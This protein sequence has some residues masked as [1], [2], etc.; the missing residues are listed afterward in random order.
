MYLENGQAAAF[1]NT[2]EP[3]VAQP[4]PRP[5]LSLPPPEGLLTGRPSEACSS[6]LGWTS[7]LGAPVKDIVSTG[8]SPESWQRNLSQMKM[9]TTG[10]G[11]AD[12]PGFELCFSVSHLAS[13]LGVTFIIHKNGECISCVTGC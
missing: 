13:S 10:R 5:A 1:P 6:T 12:E 3:T 8:P 11:K 9:E 7:G 2:W 4:G